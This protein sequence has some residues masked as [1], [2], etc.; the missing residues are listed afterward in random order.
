MRLKSLLFLMILVSLPTVVQADVV[1]VGADGEYT[2]IQEAIDAARLGDTVEV[3]SGTY[4]EN[5]VVNKP[6]AVRGVDTGGG[7]PVVDAGEGGS[8]LTLSAGG[9][10]LEGLIFKNAGVGRAGI[11][12]RSNNNLIT[13]NCVIE[14]GWYGIFLEGSSNNTIVNNTV[15]KNKYGIWIAISSNNNK[16]HQNRFVD[17]EN[18][19]TTDLGIN[20]WDR[21]LYGDLDRFG[22]IYVVPGGS[23]VDRNPSRSEDEK[24]AGLEYTPAYWLQ[25][26]D[27]LEKR[28]EGDEA[29]DCYGKALEI[30]PGIADA[31]YKKGQILQ[32]KGEGDEAASC[33]GEA[34]EIDPD[35]AD[36]WYNRAQILQT[37]GDFNEA[38]SC[39]GEAL[40]IDPDIADAWY[41]RAQILQT[42]GDF[43]EAASCYGEA[44]PPDERRF[45]R[46]CELLRRSARDRPRNRRCLVQ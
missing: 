4:H 15:S 30:D 35:I 21:N 19:N 18:R 14:N 11:E 2:G 8:A 9:V 40:E 41:N 1:T 28:G 27:A 3:Q 16:I 29:A 10:R 31:W 24:A 38:A 13:D 17:N 34:L 7:K 42:R 12:V 45:Q 37:R 22:A 23:N 36:A 46:G 39:Y 20:Q 6:L 43:N 26:G 5:I 32:M 25:R 33:Y 44:D